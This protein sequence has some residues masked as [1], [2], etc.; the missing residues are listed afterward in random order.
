M[1]R[2]LAMAWHRSLRH[3][4]APGAG[5]VRRAAERVP[6]GQRRPDF[7]A[8]GLR[9]RPKRGEID[10]R[11]FAVLHHDLAVHNNGLDIVADATL[12][13]AFHRITHRPVAQTVTPRKIDDD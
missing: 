1:H 13:Q 11:N 2:W 6:I 7:L 12:Y 10:A 3:R 5:R 8:R 9:L 4:I